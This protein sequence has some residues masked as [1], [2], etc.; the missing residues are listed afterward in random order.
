VSVSDGLAQTSVTVT[1]TVL[2]N[3]PPT[4]AA[5]GAQTVTAAQ[6]VSLQMNG[7]DTDGDPVSF[8]AVGLPAGL[9]IDVSTGRITGTPTA[10]VAGS[11]AVTVTVTDGVGTV[12]QT[13]TLT[14]NRSPV[15]TNPGNRSVRAGSFSLNIAA[16]DLDGQALSY[17][18]TGLPAGVAINGT[19]GVISGSASEGAYPVVVTV[20]DGFAQATAGFTLTATANAAPMLPVLGDRVN[21]TNDIVSLSI[22]ATD[23]DGHSVTYSA[24]GLPAGLTLNTTTGLITGTPSITGR[25]AVVLTATDGALTT[26]RSLVW[27]VVQP[28]TDD[29]LVPGV[30]M[31]RAVHVTELRTRVNMAR[32]ARSLPVIVWTDPDLAA[33]VVRAVHITELRLALDAVYVAAQVAAPVYTDPVLTRAPI[34]AVHITELRAAVVTIE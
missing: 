31:M 12:S 29:P 33:T 9:T 34:R 20:S 18:A 2:A 24:K 19:T 32:T 28:F 3:G 27:K 13:F 4:L 15:I 6:P 22:S 30:T 17:S 23:A 14:V 11:H 10:T 21:D 25:H 16:S 7:G 5:P 1:L 8:S 26:E